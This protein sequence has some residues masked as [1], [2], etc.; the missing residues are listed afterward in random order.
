[1]TQQTTLT[2]TETE[3]NAGDDKKVLYTVF[4]EHGRVNGAATQPHA[5]MGQCGR[6]FSSALGLS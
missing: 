3:G 5:R 4:R 6:E 1:M 2:L